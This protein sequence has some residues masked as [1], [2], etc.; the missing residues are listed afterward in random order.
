MKQT[1]FEN[2]E[3][4]FIGF[5]VHEWP[6]YRHRPQKSHIGRSLL[7]IPLSV[8]DHSYCCSWLANN[9]NTIT[10]QGNLAGVI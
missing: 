4:I 2:F 10:R 8:C 5:S 9:N 3:N 6:I 1:R 7:A